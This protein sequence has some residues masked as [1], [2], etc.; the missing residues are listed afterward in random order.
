MQVLFVRFCTIL[1]TA[2]YVIF[3]GE[4][5]EEPRSMRRERSMKLPMEV[6]MRRSRRHSEARFPPSSMWRDSFGHRGEGW[7]EGVR[8]RSFLP[9]AG[10][11]S[12]EREGRQVPQPSLPSGGRRCGSCLPCL[13][14]LSDGSMRVAALSRATMR[15]TMVA[16]M[17]AGIVGSVAP[18]HRLMSAVGLPHTAPAVDR[19]AD[20]GAAVPAG[21][22]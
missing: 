17:T 15:R 21:C 2:C 10:A 4:K 16:A 9:M 13:A 1:W 7:S 6:P 8:E 5:P 11:A 18:V 12:T 19:G 20:G 3:I 22:A 14:C